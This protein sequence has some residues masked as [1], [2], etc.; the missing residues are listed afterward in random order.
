MPD[1]HDLRDMTPDARDDAFAARI[2]APL[3]HDE[4]I[5]PTLR[6]RVLSTIHTGAP[7]DLRPAASGWR[8]ARRRSITPVWIGLAAAACLAGAAFVGGVIAR[9][10]T[11]HG[12][13]ADVASTTPPAPRADTVWMV[14]FVFVAP[15]AKRVALVGDFNAWDRDASRLSRSN[16]PGEW[17]TTVAL[18]AGRHEYA[19]LVDGVRWA[20]DPNA[21]SMVRD[22][23][24]VQS[25]VVV[26]DTSSQA[27]RT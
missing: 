13:R 24:G 18:P 3:R 11:T 6:E 9:S 1:H 16:G 10:G 17:T 27:R 21:T 22:E 25:S 5:D 14:K 23:F 8:G 2:A 19:F 4:P 26:V 12:A 7:A 20:A 15:D